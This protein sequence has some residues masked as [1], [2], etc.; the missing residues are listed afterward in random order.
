MIRVSPAPS[1]TP[2]LPLDTHLGHLDRVL[3]RERVR[4][5]LVAMQ[6]RRDEEEDHAFPAELG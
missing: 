5:L 6:R 3:A 1:A 2:P 4:R